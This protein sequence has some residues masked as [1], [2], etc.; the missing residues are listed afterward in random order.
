MAIIALC[1]TAVLVAAAAWTDW[2]DRT[3]SNAVVLGLVGLWCIAAAFA[4]EAL[5]GSILASLTCA[6]VAM[7]AS[8]ALFLPGWLGAGDGKLMAALALWLGP[9]D[10]AFALLASAA[11]HFVLLLP[12]TVPASVPLVGRLAQDLRSRGIPFALVVAP[13]AV[14]LLCARALD[15]LAVPP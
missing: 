3:V 11:F 6:A 1:A 15:G 2:R 9:Q 14:T 7:V 10:L 12:A 13:A 4:P 5:G 8:F